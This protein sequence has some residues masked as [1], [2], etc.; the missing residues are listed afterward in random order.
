[1]GAP[2]AS[3][4]CHGKMKEILKGLEGVVQIKDDLVVHGVGKEH[5]TRLD[6]TLERL[7]DYGVTLRKEKCHLGQREVIFF[8]HVFSKEGMSPDPEKVEHIKSWPEPKEKSEVKS[9]LQTVQFVAPY[10]RVGPRET[11]S[12]VTKPL[13]ELTRHGKHFR[14]DEE[15]RSSFRRLRDLLAADSVLVNYDPKRRTRVYVDHGPE[16]IAST[17]AQAYKVEGERKD[18]WRTVYHTSRALTK[19]EKNYGKIEGE[20]LAVF[21]G[22]KTN[23]RY[24]H[25]TSF[26]IVT[27]HE[28]LVPLYNNPG[29]PAPVRVERHRSKLT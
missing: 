21:S 1:M 16:G 3:A 22:T 23:S 26:E 20:S 12:D 28:P 6:R 11:Y 25:G 27:D 24:L 29:R 14:W 5:D 8:G 13:R 2:P 9:F 18:Q 10:M 7:R 15:C 17:I 4:E 19:A